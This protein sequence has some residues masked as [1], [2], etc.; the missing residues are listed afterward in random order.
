MRIKLTIICFY[1]F[2]CDDIGIEDQNLYKN[3][4]FINSF[5]TSWY[6]YGWGISQLGGTSTAPQTT[7]LNGALLNDDN[8]A[9][10]DSEL[11]QATIPEHLLF[12]SLI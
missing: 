8:L 11:Y 6:E 10:E 9:P 5:G 4:S 2:S 7:T 12:L 1:L 3:E